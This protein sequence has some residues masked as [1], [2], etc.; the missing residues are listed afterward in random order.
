MSAFSNNDH[1]Q[2]LQQHSHI[3]Y[4][5]R[6]MLILTCNM[7][8]LYSYSKYKYHESHKTSAYI[9]RI[10]PRHHRTPLPPTAFSFNSKYV[11]YELIS[12][13]MQTINITTVGQTQSLKE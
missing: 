1:I 12:T 5:Y 11:C 8:T 6:C 7:T 3:S 10:K 9:I 4:A 2:Q 13:N